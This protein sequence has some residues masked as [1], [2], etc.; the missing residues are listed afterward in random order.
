[1]KGS[2]VSNKFKTYKFKNYKDKVIKPRPIY[3]KNK[4]VDNYINKNVLKPE[5]HIIT[6]DTDWIE[7]EIELEPLAL[8]LIKQELDEPPKDIALKLTRTWGFLNFKQDWMNHRKLFGLN[9]YDPQIKQPFIQDYSEN[10]SLWLDLIFFVSYVFQNKSL[11]L[12]ALQSYVINNPDSEIAKVYKDPRDINLILSDKI[13]P[14]LIFTN[15]GISGIELKSNSLFGSIILFAINN[16]Y[17]ELRKCM[18]PTC[19]KFFFVQRKGRRFCEP[20]G[21]CAKAFERMNKN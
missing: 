1:M 6:T 12:S 13:F 4:L 19:G 9:A 3:T 16:Y 21:R 18:G 11:N 14:E 20:N 10:I 7:Q 2:L 8:S 15:N 5:T 17:R